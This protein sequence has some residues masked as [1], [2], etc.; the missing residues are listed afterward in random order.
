MSPSPSPPLGPDPVSLRLD[1]Y[2]RVSRVA[3]REGDAFISPDV[4]RSTIGHYAKAHGHEV[5]HEEVDLDVSGGKLDRRGLNAI[6]DRIERGE[7]GGIAVAKLD[8]LSRAGVADALKLVERI[9]EAGGVVVAVDLN[10]DP[11]TPTG[12]LMMT[13]LLALARMERRRLS[14]S[15]KVAKARAMDRGAKIGPTP[16]GY[17]RTDNGEL[18]PDP[19]QAPHV[20]EAF[21]LARAGVQ[22]A[23]DYLAGHAPGRTWTAFTVRRF[24]A[25]RSYLGEQRYGDDV[26]HDAHEALVTL[27]AWELAQHDAPPTRRP[28]AAF[29]LSGVPSC[30]T[31]GGPMVGGRG[32]RAPDGSG[33]RTYRCAASLKTH[34]GDRCPAPATMVAA[35]LEGHVDTILRDAWAG[36]HGAVVIGDGIGLDA[37]EL[38][39]AELAGAEA[40]RRG[41][42]RDTAARAALGDAWLV[43]AAEYTKAVELAQERL[44]AVADAQALTGRVVDGYEAL[45]A[46]PPEEWGAQVRNLVEELTVERGR[47]SVESRVRL[48]PSWTDDDRPFPSDDESTVV[49]ELPSRTDVDVPA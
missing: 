22:A 44:R 30:G 4:Q 36:D 19:V 16:Y 9:Q 5:I 37:L 40:E 35:R 27:G 26:R 48:V 12:E 43:M 21:R 42:A 32:G 8:R 10:L 3:G 1:A 33:L 34:K 23:T 13:L 15:W 29:P 46:L 45:D 41:F 28:P 14:E 25:N 11:T 38:A 20:R 2:I 39:E 18:E 24:L 17:R 31:C 6:L 49:G 7:T 47:G